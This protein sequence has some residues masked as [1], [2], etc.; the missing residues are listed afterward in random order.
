MS[1]HHKTV[2]L[3]EA[4]EGLSIKEGGVYIDAT[5]GFGGHSEKICQSNKNITLIGIDKDSFAIKSSEERLS[6]FAH[7][8]FRAIQ[9]DFRNIKQFL[10]E[11]NVKEINGIV[12][13]L[14]VSS[15]Q[16]DASGRGFTFQKDEPLS[17]TLSDDDS[18]L[19]SAEDVVND[20]SEESLVSIIEGYGEERFARR[21][22]KSIVERRKT[23]RFE[24]TLELVECIKSSVPG[25][26]RN[27][28]INP[29]TKTFQAIRIAVNDELGAV[30]QS[31]ND[32]LE[33]LAPNG[34]IAVITFHSLEDRLIKRIFSRFEEEG[35]GK[36]VNKK[37]IKPSREEV[38]EN[39]RSRSAKLRIFE[40]N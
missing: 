24:T 33:K 39:P 26:Y 40:K 15:Y 27:G 13:D 30:E 6:K 16:I 14:G 20:W 38:L 12:Y 11:Q 25:F 3:N 23:K 21:I 32:V 28:K 2:L 7:C 10:E 5:L 34:K 9:G 29:A 17:M 37:V 4:I 18:N 35:K 36:R 8:H 1:L 31:L 19:F 22:A